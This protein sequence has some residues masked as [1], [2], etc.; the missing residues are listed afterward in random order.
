MKLDELPE[1][2]REDYHAQLNEMLVEVTTDCTAQ[3]D[4]F[5]GILLSIFLD[6]A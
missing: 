5:I 6:Y 4:I 2:E 1:N 3:P